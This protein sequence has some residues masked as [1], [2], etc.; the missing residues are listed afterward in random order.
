MSARLPS[1]WLFAAA[2][3]AAEGLTS[4][5]VAQ[6]PALPPA[7][8]VSVLPQTA[9]AARPVQGGPFRVVPMP[10]LLEEEQTSEHG[11]LP[12]AVAP[13]PVPAMPRVLR[14]CGLPDCDRDDDERMSA[15]EVTLRCLLFTINPLAAFLP[16]H[17]ELPDG[18]PPDAYLQHPPQYFPPSPPFPAVGLSCEMLGM[19]HEVE[20]L[21]VMPVEEASEPQY[22][23]LGPWVDSASLFPLPAWPRAEL[24]VSVHE[25]QTG[26]LRFGV[27]VEVSRTGTVCVSTEPPAEK[28]ASAAC[29]AAK[30]Q[31]QIELLVAQV[32]G[33]AARALSL[34]RTADG[35][36]SRWVIEDADED[37]TTA[38]KSGLVGLRE[39]GRAKVLSEPRLVTLSGQ[40]ANFLAGG[41]QAVPRL[42]GS[43][44]VGVRFEEFGTRVHCLPVVLPDGTVRLE[45]EPEISELC[46]TS[47]VAVQGS[48][49]AG[50]T[51]GRRQRLPGD[52]RDAHRRSA[53]G[54][55]LLSGRPA[56]AHHG[57][58]QPVGEPAPDRARDGALLDRRSAVAPDAGAR[59]RRRR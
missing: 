58:P 26:S 8:P 36:P 43:G 53:A 3:V 2:L 37:R 57:P 42:D 16:M 30:P 52:A 18:P 50:R 15:D 22:Q 48:V 44:E 12:H 38:L 6:A 51:A 28:K 4:A 13:P 25:A 56:A 33:T 45:V 34:D 23:L 5:A 47:A 17:T 14:G 10:L 49:V 32:T 39:K 1:R 29:T 59:P 11:D 40:P 46:E 19:P 41:E 35:K 20:E 27:G 24:K 9:P 54:G 21:G 55:R 7:P 31:V